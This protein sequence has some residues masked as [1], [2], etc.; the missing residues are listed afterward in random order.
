MRATAA[1]SKRAKLLDAWL[2]GEF[3]K[4]ELAARKQQLETIITSSEQERGRLL[5]YLEKHALTEDQIATLKGF[6]QTARGGLDEA[7]SDFA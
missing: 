2:D 5:A 3:E 1:R 7:E 6:A 4:E